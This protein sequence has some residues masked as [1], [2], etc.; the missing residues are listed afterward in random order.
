MLTPFQKVVC[1]TMDKAIG[2]QARD[3]A[4]KATEGEALAREGNHGPHYEFPLEQG[5][6]IADSQR[7]EGEIESNWAPQPVGASLR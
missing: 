6:C 7:A 3:E 5:I 1:R 4:N 2:C